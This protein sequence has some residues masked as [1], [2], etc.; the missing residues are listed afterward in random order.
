MYTTLGS[1]LNEQTPKCSVKIYH[2]LMINL[3]SD[4]L[5][6]TLLGAFPTSVQVS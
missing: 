6:C 1:V 5:F 4:F 3:D 2:G